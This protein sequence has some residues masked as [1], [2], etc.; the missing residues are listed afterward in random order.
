[1]VRVNFKCVRC[2]KRSTKDEYDTQRVRCR[3]CE[4][5]VE[6]YAKKC[7]KIGK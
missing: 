7:K 4:D 3:A 6:A 5:W 1:M 2:D